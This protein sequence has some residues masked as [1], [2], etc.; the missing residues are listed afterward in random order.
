MAEAYSEPREAV[1]GEKLL[2]A[3]ERLRLEQTVR[4][5]HASATS[6]A[7]A[8]K[9]RFEELHKYYAPAAGD[10]WPEDKL[11]RPGKLH[12]TANM[13]RAF[14]D[15]EARLLSILPR[16]T[17]KPDA[18]DDATQRRAEV[19]EELFM[20]WLEASGWDLWMS[21]LNRGA[22]LYGISY[23]K[24]FWNEEE[25]R[26]DVILVEQPQNL[27]VG[28]GS[29]DFRAVDWAIYSYTVS[30][31]EAMERWPDCIVEAQPGRRDPLIR[32]KG[33]SHDDP[34][35]QRGLLATGLSAVG[36]IVS[37]TFKQHALD[38]EYE[39]LHL[40]AWD[41]WY[42][43]P[44][45]PIC[46]ATFL[47]GTLVDGP[48]EHPEYPAIPYIPVERDHEPGS[49]DGMSTAELLIDIQNGYNRAM[50]DMAQYVAD[51][52]ATAWQLTGDNADSVPEGIVPKAG[53][54]VAAG[55]G[56][57]IEPIT[58]G[59]N[60]YPYQALIDIH[61]DAAHKITG[62]SEVLFGNLPGSQTAGRAL[63]VQIEAAINRLDPKRR[64]LYEGLRRLMLFWGYMVAKQDVKVNVTES[65]AQDQEE[66]LD[67]AAVP[68]QPATRQISIGEII[69]GLNRWR[70]V[71]P[72]IT[73]RDVMEH[74]QTT[75]DKVTAK[76]LPLEWAMDEVGV[77]NPKMAKALIE[78]ERTNPGL[79]PMD[80]Q[81][82]AA[83][84]ATLLQLMQ[85]AMAMEAQQGGGAG[86]A[87]EAAN[88]GTG[89]QAGAQ[90][91]AQQAAPTRT[92]DQ[93]SPRTQAGSAPPPGA[94]SPLGG[95][96][97]MLV[98]QT[99]GGESQA[100]S[101]ISTSRQV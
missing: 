71:A 29:S 92:E 21:D 30:A 69:K 78:L 68:P 90:A 50:S 75:I 81:A 11:R 76:L 49:P 94:P 44:G 96:L 51:E 85:A 27:M 16:I 52:T 38:G 98:R 83:V 40:T 37:S 79:F 5:R 45:G 4:A 61:W 9:S 86:A 19:V 101:Q 2:S 89:Q 91:A 60:Q 80:A 72:E 1:D 57:R 65:T 84:K 82:T 64:R 15:T 36:R 10:Q 54:I 46:N 99:P 32:S 20:R 67:P 25:E 59:A 66:V 13:V 88:E 17:N 95:E 24:P 33:S 34:L 41:Y 56:N 62:L 3:V 18:Q 47:N 93:N 22:S 26:P 87:V 23:L 73:P 53:E 48:H 14:V 43:K 42:K 7:S 35:N 63:A 70:I 100:M 28:W 77:E 74:T 39:Q 6:R 31:T 58:R 8:N 55:P 12:Y 97:Q